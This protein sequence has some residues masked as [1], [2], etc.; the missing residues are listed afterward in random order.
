MTPEEILE[1][2]GSVCRSLS[3]ARSIILATTELGKT[4]PIDPRPNAE[5]GNLRLRP[6]AGG[7]SVGVKVLT[8]EELEQARAAGEELYVVHFDTCPAA[9]RFRRRHPARG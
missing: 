8:G 5:R 6:L 2:N 7:P 4:M 3:C 1:A 9:A